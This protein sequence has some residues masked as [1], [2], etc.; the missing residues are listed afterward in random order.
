MSNVDFATLNTPEGYKAFLQAYHSELAEKRSFPPLGLQKALHTAAPIF[1]HNDWNVMAAALRQ[2]SEQ[3]ETPFDYPDIYQLK[4]GNTHHEY[5]MKEQY[6][7]LLAAFKKIAAGATAAK[8]PEPEPEPEPA[9]EPIRAVWIVAREYDADTEAVRHT[10]TKSVRTWEEAK[11]Y[12]RDL[13]HN[14]AVHNDR[15]LSEIMECRHITFPEPEE[16]EEMSNR[17][18]FNWIAENNGIDELITLADYLDYNLYKI[19]VED[20]WI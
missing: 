3:Q 4:N 10:Q 9:P 7:A 15:Q 18:L 19:T 1:G 16:A 2:A 14:K 13:A 17:E 6:D 12:V 8:Q 20:H 11:D 5:V